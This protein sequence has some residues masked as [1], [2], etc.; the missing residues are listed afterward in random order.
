MRIRF[1]A[2]LL[3]T[4]FALLLHVQIA[5]AEDMPTADAGLH[6]K[7]STAQS[8][9]WV[10]E[11]IVWQV[12][13]INLS[14]ADF[15]RIRLRPTG[16]AWSWPG[17]EVAMEALSPGEGIV[18]EV[19]GVTLEEGEVWLALR[20]DWTAEKT[21]HSRLVTMDR[22][23]LVRPIRQA[24]GGQIL[25]DRSTVHRGDDLPLT[26]QI[27]NNSPFPLI[28]VTVTGQGTDLV[29]GQ[30]AAGVDVPAGEARDISLA[31]RV[32]GDN[33]QANLVVDFDWV[34]AAGK[35]ASAQLLLESEQIHSKPRI[36]IDIPWNTVMVIVGFVLG[37]LSWWLQFRQERQERRRVNCERALGMLHLVQVQARHGA[38]A[39]AE[40]PLDLLQKLFSEQGLYA[41]IKRL[42][43]R[44]PGLS[45]CVG[46]LWKAAYQHNVCIHHPDGAERQKA[47]QVQVER[48]ELVLPGIKCN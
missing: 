31:P 7:V 18:I 8:E 11:S 35:A 24:I 1:V 20:V 32:D 37:Q 21:R 47:L 23:L 34:D 41:A 38:D 26:V 19:R 44:T 16:D 5:R 48:L 6:A 4:L 3:A 46:H 36:P 30:P 28:G 42:E 43:K 45:S 39:G 33:P 22:P 2:S 13:L 29:W 14:D 9:A 15:S 25:L 10:G 40:V 17:G 12:S 27:I